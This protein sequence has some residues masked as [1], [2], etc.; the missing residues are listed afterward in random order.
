MS[1][2]FWKKKTLSWNERR[3]REFIEAINKLKNFHVTDRGGFSIDP[4]E[5]REQVIAS[6]QAY[7]SLVAGSSRHQQQATHSQHAPAAL[8]T[9]ES[10]VGQAYG[11][12]YQ[13]IVTWRRLTSGAS[14]RYVCLQDLTTKRYTVAVADYFSNPADDEAASL[15]SVVTQ[16]VAKALDTAEFAWFD[17]CGEA[18]DGFDKSI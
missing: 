14:V 7:S 17:T 18:M 8:E 4:E 13:E 16:R 1:W 6:R 12:D 15:D 2:K 3:E 10:E 5:L 11:Y 9:P